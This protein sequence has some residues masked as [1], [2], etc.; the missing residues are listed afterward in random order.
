MAELLV[1][2]ELVPAPRT[3]LNRPMGTDRRLLAVVRMS[4]AEVKQIKAALGGTVNDVVLALCT[5]SGLR[6]VLLAARR[7]AARA[8]AARPGPGRRALRRGAAWRSATA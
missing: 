8:R 4:L 5:A 1:R 2:D 7:A 3:S 6:L